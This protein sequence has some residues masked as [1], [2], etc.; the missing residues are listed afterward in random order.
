MW[1]NYSLNSE[2][3]INIHLFT[4]KL[5]VFQENNN[6]CV[7]S[8]NVEEAGLSVTIGKKTQFDSD[9]ELNIAISDSSEFHIVPCFPE[10][11][12]L[13]KAIPAFRIMPNAKITLYAFCPIGIQ[14]Y[15]SHIRPEYLLY[16]KM[17]V[18]LSQA[19]LGQPDAGV[20]GYSLFDSVDL[21]PN[22]PLFHPWVACCE[23]VFYND[24]KKMV[25][26]VK[27]SIDATRLRIYQNEGRLYTSNVKIHHKD[28]DAPFEIEYLQS[29]PSGM[30]RAVQVAN[31]RNPEETNILAKSYNFLKAIAQQR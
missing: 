29:K 31:A 4:H 17:S 15:A 21:Q 8:K 22:S 16:E 18:H 25:E 27:F 3:Q 28:E 9:E 13:L 26:P 12:L 10:R 19:W 14:I 23:I 5:L 20:L 6:L 11:A 30:G 7:K 2:N 24:S 1:D